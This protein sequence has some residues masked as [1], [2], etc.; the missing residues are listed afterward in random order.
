MPRA[1]EWSTRT[2][3][4]SQS[5]LDFLP[6]R[7][8]GVEE[9]AAPSA[10]GDEQTIMELERIRLKRDRL[11]EWINEPFFERVQ[12]SPRSLNIV[13]QPRFIRS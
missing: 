4:W 5:R 2:L 11:E 13:A 3:H 9:T 10:G 7:P 1:A 8:S 6:Y 12:H